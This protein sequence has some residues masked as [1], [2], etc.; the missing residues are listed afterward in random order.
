[1]EIGQRIGR[2]FANW[3]DSGKQEPVFNYQVVTASLGEDNVESEPQ[4]ESF[5]AMDHQRMRE[6]VEEMDAERIQILKMVEERKITAEEAAKLL[7]A[8]ETATPTRSNEIAP[9]TK[10]RWLRVRVTDLATGR[11]KV[12]VN[13]PIGVIS[14]AGKLGVRF[15]LQ[16]YVD[17]DRL[18]IDELIEAIR[19]GAAG[20][21]VDVTSEESSEH[22]EVYVE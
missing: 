20:K 11:A 3:K 10:A 18:D 17:Q 12:N 2:Y 14:V 22:V 7:A 4:G 1:M 9:S 8:L 13:V 16:K 19:T 5:G 15:G 21:L 6:G